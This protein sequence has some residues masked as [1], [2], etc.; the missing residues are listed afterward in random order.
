M[1]LKQCV[2]CHSY[3]EGRLDGAYTCPGCDPIGS[4]RQLQSLDSLFEPL[5]IA[6]LASIARL[7]PARAGRENRTRR[8]HSASA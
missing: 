4:R 5:E 6:F 7:A 1:I 3:F 2:S 8:T